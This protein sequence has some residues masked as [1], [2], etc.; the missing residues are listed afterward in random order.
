MA[1]ASENVDAAEARDG[2][3]SQEKVID[4]IG[5]EVQ[6]LAESAAIFFQKFSELHRETE[7]ESGTRRLGDLA[8]HHLEATKAACKHVM[9]HSDSYKEH[10]KNMK[11]FV[12][13]ANVDDMREWAKETKG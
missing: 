13:G 5:K 7:G 3:F 11:R 2:D 10:E 9:D 4:S 8:K 6:V 1:K 12:P